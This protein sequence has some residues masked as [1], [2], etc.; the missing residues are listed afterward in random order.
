MPVNATGTT[1]LRVNAVYLTGR[2]H[3]APS[4]MQQD[5]FRKPRPGKADSVQ[6]NSSVTISSL[7]LLA[8]YKFHAGG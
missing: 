2:L 7:Q 6:L 1:C 8:T 3:R 5:L 4:R